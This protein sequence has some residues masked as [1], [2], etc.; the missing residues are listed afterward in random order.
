MSRPAAA[1]L[2]VA[3]LMAAA[4]VQ[5]SCRE[6]IAA[7]AT[8]HGVPESAALTV[9]MVESGHDPL[10]LNIAGWPARARSVE[11][12]IAALAK[13][14]A[15]GITLVDVGCM[16]INL[17]HH[18]AAFPRLEDAF[19]PAANAD[20][21]VRLLKRLHAEKGS[22]GKAIAA[23]HSSDPQRQKIYLQR[24]KSR[25]AQDLATAR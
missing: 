13:L 18:P 24:V 3:A 9:G 12:G 8:R 23:Y 25:L 2:A 16:Q 21:G 11:H 5:A 15:A 19:T 7:A 4:P 22:W 17:K 20:Y 1:L 14:R 6:E 10:A